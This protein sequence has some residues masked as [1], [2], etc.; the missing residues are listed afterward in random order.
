MNIPFIFLFK[1]MH[2][3]Y[4]IFKWHIFLCQQLELKFF[5][6]GF[7]YLKLFLPEIAFD[8]DLSKTKTYFY[9]SFLIFKIQI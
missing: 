1:L 9:L 8:D 6:Y 5:A 7:L 4:W 2:D 3:R